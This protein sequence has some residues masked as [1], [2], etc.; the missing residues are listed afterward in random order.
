MRAF[1]RFSSVEGFPSTPGLYRAHLRAARTILEATTEH[2]YSLFH[3]LFG[4]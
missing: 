1:R 4:S 3:T 2:A